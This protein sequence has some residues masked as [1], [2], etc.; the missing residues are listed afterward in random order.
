MWF[1][2]SRIDEF[3]EHGLDNLKSMH[4]RWNCDKKLEKINLSSYEIFS[5]L[6]H[7]ETITIQFN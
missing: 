2:V 1:M 5:F 3:D 4:G 6:D 7:N